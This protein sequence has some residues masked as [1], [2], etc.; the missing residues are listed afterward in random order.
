MVLT[1]DGVPVVLHDLYLDA[2]TDVAEVFPNRAD[3]AAEPGRRY[4]VLNFTLAE[5][6][7]LRASERFDPA[8]GAAV[9]PRRFP[10]HTGDF[11][12]PTLA[13]ELT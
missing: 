7:R 8:T 11:E 10:A 4:S 3:P 12:V 13:E 9:F 1:R 5:V 6:K 2:T